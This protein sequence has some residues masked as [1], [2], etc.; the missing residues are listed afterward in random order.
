MA[1]WE[2]AHTRDILAMSIVYEIS[3]RLDELVNDNECIHSWIGYVK[4]LQ[5]VRIMEESAPV[6]WRTALKWTG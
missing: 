4:A 2:V 5:E 3:Q 1:P 6:T